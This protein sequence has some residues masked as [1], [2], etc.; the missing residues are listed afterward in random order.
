M[1]TSSIGKPII[2]DEEA[3][4]RFQDAMSK[5]PKKIEVADPKISTAK[6]HPSKEDKSQEGLPV[7]AKIRSGGQSGA[8]RGAVDAAIKLGI[9]YGG[10]VPKGGWAEDMPVA[11]G[12]LASYPDFEECEETSISIHTQANVDES[13]V[14]LIVGYDVLSGGT[15]FTESYAR[16]QGKPVLVVRGK[17]TSEVYEWMRSIG[18]ELDV[19]IAGPRASEQKDAY[20]RAFDLVAALVEMDRKALS[21]SR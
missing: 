16:S 19:N 12:V 10:K 9:P 11:P 18:R 2:L 7:I 17:E 21:R 14:T 5:A 8:D 4:K 6:I 1:A 3:S 15:M 20:R 13:D